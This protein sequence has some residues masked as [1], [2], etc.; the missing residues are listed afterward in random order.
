MSARPGTIKEIVDVELPRPRWRSH[1]ETN[2]DF[3]RLE[4]YLNELL[5]HDIRRMATSIPAHS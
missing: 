5:E 1:A 4:G 3:L 2:Q